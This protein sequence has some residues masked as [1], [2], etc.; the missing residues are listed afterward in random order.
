MNTTLIANLKELIATA[1]DLAIVMHLNPDGDAMG[2]ALA[3]YQSVLSQGVT[4]TVVSPTPISETLDW[5]PYR[6]TVFVFDEKQETHK[7]RLQQFD[8]VVF[9][10]HSST[11]RC[12]SVVDY[13]TMPIVRR[14]YIDHHP[15]PDFEVGIAISEAESA[16]T[17]CIL[18]EVLCALK[19][20]INTSIA[21]CLYTGIV[22]DTG[23]FRYGKSIAQVF[24]IASE[25]VLLGI[26]KEAITEA[27]YHTH[28]ENRLRLLG[29]VLKEKMQRVGKHSAYITLRQKEIEGL[30]A[31]Y[32][33]TE[34]FVNY[35]LTISDVFVSAIFIEKED[36]I[37]LSFRSRKE[38][39][40]NLLARN[41]FNGGG[42]KNASGGR[43]YGTMQEAVDLYTKNII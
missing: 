36:Y 24:R 3:L 34:D 5:L 20:P 37:K 28:S 4:A 23:N 35:P 13:L 39:D 6:E 16:A 42:H 41:H 40:V 31:Q 9:L 8:T 22:T 29:F 30:G 18:Y 27:I 17:C 2:S 19:F 21:S 15:S 10:D 38:F 1:K 14:A 11:G 7:K 26:D 32:S 12:G 33:D 25:L 43:F